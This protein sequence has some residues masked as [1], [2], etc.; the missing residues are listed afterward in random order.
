[1]IREEVGRGSAGSAGA[2]LHRHTL[3][4]GEVILVP[5]PAVGICCRRELEGS[6]QE[7]SV[8]VPC[9][10]AGRTEIARIGGTARSDSVTVGLVS[11]RFERTQS[12][13]VNILL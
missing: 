7:H 6:V 9:H 5:C 8:H 10:I 4:P 3:G 2:S 11:P 13:L 12:L 1:M